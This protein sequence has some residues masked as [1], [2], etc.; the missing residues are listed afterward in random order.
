M[1]FTVSDFNDLKQLLATHPEWQV[2]LRHLLLTEDFQALPAIVRDLAEAQRRAEERLTRLEEAVAQ[3]VEAQRGVEER[4]A[5]LEE[6]VAQLVEAQRRTD[7][8]MAEL[9][10]AQRGIEQRVARLEEAVAQL[11]ESQRRFEERM[12]RFEGRMD[13]FEVKLGRVQGYTL[14]IRY[15]LN[16]AAYF[17]AW[18][19]RTEVVDGN[20]LTDRT[21]GQLNGDELR[22][23]LSTDLV[24]RGRI[25]QSPTR[26]EVWL[27]VEIS[28]VVD[29]E[30]VVRAARRAELLRRAG[31]PALPVVAGENATIGAEAEAR[32]RGAAILQDGTALLWDEALAAWPV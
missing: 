23:L 32:Q 21:E 28:S 8:R 11:A 25:A 29:R 3:L 6:V 26:P 17:G 1:A 9:V 13:R 7:Q 14:E 22:E 5:R 2:E 18:L 10:E 19:R 31:L 15:R 30:D 24:V 12:D 16:A 20:E 4:L 27:A